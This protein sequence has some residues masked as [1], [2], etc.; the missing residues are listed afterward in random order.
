MPLQSGLANCPKETY[1][2][3]AMGSPV[4]A[5][6]LEWGPTTKDYAETEP[7]SNSETKRGRRK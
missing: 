7:P 3:T 1:S 6:H 2:P 4:L 5:Q